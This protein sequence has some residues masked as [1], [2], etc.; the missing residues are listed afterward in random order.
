MAMTDSDRTAIVGLFDDQTKADKAV[1]ELRAAGFSD[2]QISLEVRSARVTGEDI[3]GDQQNAEGR[4][5]DTAGETPDRLQSYSEVSRTVVTVKAE[6]RE[7]EALGILHRNGA[8]NANIPDALEADLAPILG[9]ETDAT[10]SRS[11][12]V[13]GPH[14]EDSFFDPKI[15]PQTP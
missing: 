8:N 11:R 1:N 3:T 6:G 2:N 4:E 7:Q 5:E 10:A 9:S 12:R 14:S 13:T 15:N